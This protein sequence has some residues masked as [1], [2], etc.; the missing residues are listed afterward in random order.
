MLAHLPGAVLVYESGEALRIKKASRYAQGR[1]ACGM[2]PSST[3][4]YSPLIA[5]H[6]RPFFIREIQR[7]A[8][9]VSDCGEDTILEIAATVFKDPAYRLR[10]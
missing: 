10:R 1:F 4:T 6:S 3:P 8:Q 9:G 7:R 2:G 5:F